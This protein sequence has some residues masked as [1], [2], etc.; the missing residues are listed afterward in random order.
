MR[1]KTKTRK[2]GSL[3]KKIL[4]TIQAFNRKHY[5]RKN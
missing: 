1:G 3:R 4:A 5:S 2:Q